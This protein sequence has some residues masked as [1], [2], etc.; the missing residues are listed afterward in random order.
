MQNFPGVTHSVCRRR[1][2][3]NW[4]WYS[5]TLGVP[6]LGPKVGWTLAGRVVGR[7]HNCVEPQNGPWYTNIQLLVRTEEQK[8]KRALGMAWVWRSQKRQS[9]ENLLWWRRENWVSRLC[10][11]CDVFSFPVYLPSFLPSTLSNSSLTL[12]IFFPT[13]FPHH[14]AYTFS[15]TGK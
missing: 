10:L 1:H 15:L 8:G 13:S 7:K 3:S 12:P 9:T 2:L 5:L 14:L 4:E 11:M 6:K